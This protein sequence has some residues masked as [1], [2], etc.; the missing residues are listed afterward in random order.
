MVILTELGAIAAAFAGLIVILAAVPLLRRG[1][2]PGPMFNPEG[3]ARLLVAEIR[4]HHGEA[5]EQARADKSVYDKLKSDVERSRA[6]F[7]KRFP[8]DG[9]VYDAAVVRYLGLDIQP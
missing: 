7:L 5:V 4:L 3:F 1:I 6:I 8:A 9:R 2:A